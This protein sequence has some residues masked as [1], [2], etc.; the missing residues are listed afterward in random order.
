M[1]PLMRTLKP[2]RNGPLY[3][4]MVTGT[5]AV[6]GWAVAFGTVR[7]GWVGPSSLLPAVPN[8]TSHPSTASALTS[9][10]SMWHYNY[11]CTLKG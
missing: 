4:N 10:Y 5:L 1:N 3:I 2:H 7:R 9:Y 6:D 8:V 11:L